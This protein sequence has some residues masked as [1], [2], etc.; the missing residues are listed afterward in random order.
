MEGGGVQIRVRDMVFVLK[1]RWKMILSLTLVGLVFGIVLF[2]MT[3][4]QDSIRS[5]EVSGSFAIS[6]Q[7][8]SDGVYI[9][10]SQ[11]ANNNDFHL[12]EDMVDAVAYVLRSNRVLEQVIQQQGLLG[13]TVDELRSNLSITQ[14]QATQIIEMR[15]TWRTAEEAQSIWQA[16][17]DAANQSIPTALQLGQLTVIDAPEVRQSSVAGTGKLLPVLLTML[18]FCCGIGIAL[19]ELIL[20]P[21]LTNPRDAE[22]MFGLE[23]IGIIP[24][25]ELFFRSRQGSLLTSS[26]PDRSNVLQ[27]YSA[28][29]Y[30]LRNRLGTKEQHH[31]FYVTS[32]TS[33]EGKSTVAANLAIQLSDMEHRTLLIDFD[34]RNPSLGTLFM[35]KVD[36][37]HSL[38]ALYRGDATEEDAIT[39]LTGYLD[40]LPSVLEHNAMILDGVITDMI[41]RLTD[42][43]EYII[44]D[45]APVGEVSETLSLNRVANTVL[46]VIRYDSAPLPAIQNALEKLDKSGI[47]VL[48]CVVNGVG[49][50]GSKSSE[51][52]KDYIHLPA[53]PKAKKQPRKEKPKR[54]KKQPKPKK[55]VKAAPPEPAP[56][57]PAEAAVPVAEK[58]KAK[59][60][61]LWKLKD[62]K[63]EKPK[64]IDKHAKGAVWAAERNQ[65]KEKQQ[66][67]PAAPTE[68]MLS[69][70][71]APVE[72]ASAP[73][74][75][76]VEKTPAPTVTETA[77]P[78]KTVQEAPAPEVRTT[79]S[80]MA[81]ARHDPLGDLSAEQAGERRR[82]VLSE[83]MEEE[84]TMSNEERSTQSVMDELL[85]QGRD[86]GKEP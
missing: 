70:V 74:A 11:V 13:T 27:N 21:T 31:C 58:P 23:T 73:V 36:Y 4:V 32:T 61:G 78:E 17:I 56:A 72:E 49:N 8:H 1:K 30:I 37:I 19:M 47:R 16:I 46:Y 5:Y 14:Y 7:N 83:L 84:K 48:G 65:P 82:D 69:P 52:K 9:N 45:S 26:G 38:N 42:R 40:I 77:V 2:A 80:H 33:G 39:P 35:D 54:E 50:G 18:G 6:T 55:P 24:Q 57:A 62:K 43:Y 67:P 53:K 44:M 51:D 29:A 15:F 71:V 60:F 64:Y 22:T 59:G 75:A 20:R 76:T 63:D 79:P 12:A 3:Y 81:Q 68:E 25:D 28:A 66:V 41:Q 10:G 85:Q 34:T 86:N